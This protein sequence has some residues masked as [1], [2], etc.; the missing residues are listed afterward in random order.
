[1]NLREIMKWLF[2]AALG[3]NT[4]R[5][6][7]SF[8][9]AD[10]LRL[11]PGLETLLLIITAVG[12]GIIL[13]GGGAIIAHI[14]AFRTGGGMVRWFLML[15]WILLNIFGVILLSPAITLAVSRSELAY[16][17]PPA[18]QW[19]WAV[20][21]IVSVEWLAAA[22][23][24]GYSLFQSYQEEHDE[25]KNPFNRISDWLDDLR[26]PPPHEP[27]RSKS[28]TNNTDGKHQERER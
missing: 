11:P 21:S 22:A 12:T 20:V 5:Y 10:S 14:L 8:L 13:T 19:W 1:M 3:V 27:P 15:T 26:Q 9:M 17:L 25:D 24:A 28:H 2:I 18:A 6:I 4:P 16:V 23:M 7:I